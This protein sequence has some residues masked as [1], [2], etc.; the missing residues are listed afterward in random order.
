MLPAKVKGFEI[1]S[2]DDRSAG[3]ASG[4]LYWMT[5]RCY[6]NKKWVEKSAWVS[7]KNEEDCR[8]RAMLIYKK[9]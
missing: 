5:Y 8:N 2:M 6:K 4:K 3:M 7:G 1:I 9:D